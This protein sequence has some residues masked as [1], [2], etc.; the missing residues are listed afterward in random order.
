MTREYLI[1]ER[2]DGKLVVS[3]LDGAQAIGEP[4]VWPAEVRWMVRVEAAGVRSACGAGSDRLLVADA[5]LRQA[6]E[7]LAGAS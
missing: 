4:G 5:L 3:E 1:Y 7:S 6:V 2:N